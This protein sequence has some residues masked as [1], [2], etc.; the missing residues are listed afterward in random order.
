MH[1]VVCGELSVPYIRTVM[2]QVYFVTC[3]CACVNYGM[4]F[5]IEFRVIEV[6]ILVIRQMC[7]CIVL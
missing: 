6:V 1:P 4:Y 5:E 2:V 7:G 3:R